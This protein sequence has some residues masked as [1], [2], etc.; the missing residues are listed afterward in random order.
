MKLF[1][2]QL[3]GNKLVIPLF[4]VELSQQRYY[5]FCDGISLFTLPNTYEKQLRS[6]PSLIV[7]YENILPNMKIGLEIETSKFVCGK[8]LNNNDLFDFGSFISMSL[9]LATGKPIDIPYWFDVEDDEI[10]GGGTTSFRTYILGK[11]YSS[12]LDNEN[13]KKGFDAFKKRVSEI[14][15]KYSNDRTNNLIRAISFVS[16]GFQSR[17]LFSKIVNNT[18]FLESLFSA[19]NDEVAFQIA[20]SVS[21]YL[22]S[23][24]T[25]EERLEMFSKV[26]KLYDY[27]S[28][29][30]HGSDISS[31]T[32][33]LKT[34]LKFSEELNTEIFTKILNDNHVEIFSKKKKLRQKELKK[35]SLG[36]GGVF[37]D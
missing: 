33:E 24:N 18:I 37:M 16:I 20:S 12:P 2:M 32:K 25:D 22:K 13:Q 26:K 19:S 36:A 15:D 7:G 4:H 9:S 21:W 31:I 27:R 23:K 35:L 29:I 34:N 5:N 30:V 6:M 1:E 3:V 8:K 17:N 14:V 28:K 10:K 11:R